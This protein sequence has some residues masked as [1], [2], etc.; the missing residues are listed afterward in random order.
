[1]FYFVC[2]FCF[3]VLIILMLVVIGQEQYSGI[4]I[5]YLKLLVTLIPTVYNTRG[6]HSNHYTT[7]TV[8]HDRK[9]NSRPFKQQFSSLIFLF[10]LKVYKQVVVVWCMMYIQ[11]I[12]LLESL[13]ELRMYF[14]TSKNSLEF[15]GIE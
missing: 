2:F 14:W 3:A 15:I 7:D 9:V 11:Y 6:E 1:M 8:L 10:S 5:L 4:H 13:L 12:I